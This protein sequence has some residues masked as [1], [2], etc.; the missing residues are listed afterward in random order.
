MQSGHLCKYTARGTKNVAGQM[1]SA[2]YICIIISLRYQ[3]IAPTLNLEFEQR[4]SGRIFNLLPFFE[5]KKI[6]C[7]FVFRISTVIV[8]HYHMLYRIK[9]QNFSSS[10]HSIS[11]H[12]Q[13]IKMLER[14]SVMIKTKVSKFLL[15]RMQNSAN[16]RVMPNV[17]SA[18]NV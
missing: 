5:G 12:E 14:A 13:N 1:E 4:I 7:T 11:S 16:T 10:A 3:P 18:I 6:N 8:L 17:C 15:L 9:M 2:S